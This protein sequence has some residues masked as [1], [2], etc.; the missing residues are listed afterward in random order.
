HKDDDPRVAQF[1]DAG[2]EFL[3][4]QQN[5]DRSF[6]VVKGEDVIQAPLAVTALTALAFMANG[7]TLGRGKYQRQVRSAIEYLLDHQTDYAIAGPPAGPIVDDQELKPGYFKVV[8]DTQSRTH[9]HGYATLAIA[10]AY[11]TLSLDQ[12]LGEAATSKMR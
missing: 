1:V 4:K 7:S 2:L 6:S 3:A 5:D 11:G 9:G 8:S 10:E 12:K